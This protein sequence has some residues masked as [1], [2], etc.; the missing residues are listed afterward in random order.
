MDLPAIARGL[1]SQQHLR[2]RGKACRTA[3]FDAVFVKNNGVLGEG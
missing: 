3:K 2:P 1:K